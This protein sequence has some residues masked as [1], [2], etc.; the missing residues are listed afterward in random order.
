MTQKELKAVEIYTDG[1]CSGNPG[2]GGWASIL[3]YKGHEK[4]ISGFTAETTNNRMEITAVIR[5][6]ECL[7]EP[8]DATVYTDSSYLADAVMKKWIN[9]W[10]SNGWARGRKKNEVKNLDLWLTLSELMKTHSVRFIKVAG[11]SDNLLNNRCDKLATG[12]IKKAAA[13]SRN[14]S[15]C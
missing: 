11:H 4:V 12:E 5:A 15:N 3:L 1:A 8:C 14:L 7:K 9:N 13:K 6:L 2:P 10:E